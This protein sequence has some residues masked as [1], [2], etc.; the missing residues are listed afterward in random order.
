MLKFKGGLET[1]YLG[2]FFMYFRGT[3]F[4]CGLRRLKQTRPMFSGCPCQDSH[5]IEKEY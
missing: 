2:L 4:N 1:T 3:V 5:R